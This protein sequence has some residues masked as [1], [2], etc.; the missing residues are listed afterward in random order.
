MPFKLAKAYLDQLCSYAT[1][2]IAINWN[3]VFVYVF[4]A[5]IAEG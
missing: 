5:L 1:N 3:A 4:V 2:E